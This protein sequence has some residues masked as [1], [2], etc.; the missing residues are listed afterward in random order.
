MPDNKATTDTAGPA[1]DDA[2]S[3]FSKALEE[4]KAGA[5][6]LGKEALGKAGEYREKLQ[7]AGDELSGSAREKSGEAREKASEFAN[8]GKAKASQA[9]ASLGKL[10]EEQGPAV[11]DAVGP[12]FGDY[13][14][15]AGK[16]IQDAGAR[17][18]EKSFDELGED[19]KEFVRKSP[20]VAVG[21]AA[22][23]GYLLA[24]LFNRK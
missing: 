24:R 19:A 14:R 16:G 6:A 18:D 17:L 9:I 10:I 11:D 4:A 8:D 7:V 20:A 5:E 12:K 21:M 2:R 15:R 13:A 1:G 23:A 22:A 3:H